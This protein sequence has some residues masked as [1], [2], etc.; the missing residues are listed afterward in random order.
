MYKIGAFKQSAL[1]DTRRIRCILRAGYGVVIGHIPQNA[2][3]QAQNNNNTSP[4][5]A[6]PMDAAQRKRT[7]VK[8]YAVIKTGGK[9]YKVAADDVIHVE[10]LKGEA[11]D[12][13]ELNEV[14]MVGGEGA[15]KIGT[16]LVEGAMVAAEVVKQTRGAK[17]IVFKKK[18]RQNYRRK[19]GHRQDLTAL[20]ILG[21]GV[22]GKKPS[23]KA[24]P[25]KAAAKPETDKAEAKKPA[26][27]K[28]AAKKSDATDDLSLIGGVGPVIVKKLAD[29]GY[30][31]FK[32]V[33]EMTPEQV[34]DVDEKLNFKGRIEREEW[35]EQA[36][37]LM[38]GKAPRA[39]VDQEAAKEQKK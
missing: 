14:L 18:R 37:E 24:A 34:A 11:G 5:I 20:R 26:A 31:S 27:K 36:K 30:T 12:K 39:K 32:Q 9:Q 13:V 16:P 19:K 28:P 29:L 21:I 1:L 25:K 23:V 4:H 35:I 7:R 22:D 3:S 6:A 15:P 10:K 38:A 2:L 8:M 33:A 17:I